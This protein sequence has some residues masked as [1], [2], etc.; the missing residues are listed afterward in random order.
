MVAVVG[1]DVG[2]DLKVMQFGCIF[3]IRLMT[4]IGDVYI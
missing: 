3:S 1:V 2:V 4:R